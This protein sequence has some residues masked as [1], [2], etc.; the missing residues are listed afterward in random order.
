MGGAG[1]VSYREQWLMHLLGFRYGLP[2]DSPKYDYVALLA[3]IDDTDKRA[4]DALAILRLPTAR[5][6]PLVPERIAYF[7]SKRAHLKV[8]AD[9]LIK[10][11]RGGHIKKIECIGDLFLSNDLHYPSFR[12]MEETELA[13]TYWKMGEKVQRF[14]STNLAVSMVSAV[15]GPPTTILIWLLNDRRERS[16]RDRRIVVPK[17]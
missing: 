2:C 15:L 4:E 6:E 12:E 8:L 10:Y 9:V 1:I 17:P 16:S 14:T 3:A 5:N 7:E 13:N 11:S